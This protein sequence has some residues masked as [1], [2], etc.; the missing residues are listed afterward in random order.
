MN[1]LHS[2][3]FVKKPSIH[4]SQTV[5]QDPII[6]VKV[7][8]LILEDGQSYPYSY[9]ERQHNGAVV[10]PYFEKTSSLLLVSQYR[11]PVRKIA[12]GFPGGGIEKEHDPEQTARLE[13]LEETGYEVGELIDLGPY[14]PDMGIL[15]NEGRA[16]LALNPKQVAKP[17]QNTAAETTLP[18]LFS[19]E[20]IKQMI[21]EGEIRDGWSLGPFSLFLLWLEKHGTKVKHG[22]SN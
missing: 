11:H 18:Q 14:Q 3:L 1:V 7:D 2:L 19:L 10:I 6:T 12:W 21:R 17:T 16:F 4:S 13:L 5:F 20:E 22:K 8:T 9:V 15:A